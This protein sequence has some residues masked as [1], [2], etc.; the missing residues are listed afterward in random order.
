[1]TTASE[2]TNTPE[3]ETPPGTTPLPDTT[4]RAQ[5]RALQLLD[6]MIDQQLATREISSETL[7]TVRPLT[8]LLDLLVRPQDQST[9]LGQQLAETLR[10]LAFSANETGHQVKDLAAQVTAMASRL[11][12]MMTT[13]TQMQV[14]QKKLASSSSALDRKLDRLTRDLFEEPPASAAG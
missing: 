6:T 12:G 14:A 5:T 3:A 9:E 7:A 4:T 13:L 1:M 8:A 10:Q 11:D 2:T